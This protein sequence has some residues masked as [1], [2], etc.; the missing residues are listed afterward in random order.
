MEHNGLNGFKPLYGVLHCD[1]RHG[2]E[3]LAQE[4]NSMT[5]TGARTCC[6]DLECSA[7]LGHKT[8]T[9]CIIIKTSPSSSGGGGGGHCDTEQ[10]LV[11]KIS[12]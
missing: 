8:P 2:C 12:Y 1:E 5:L 3:C 4:Y 7:L 9:K 6:L 10:D 11:F